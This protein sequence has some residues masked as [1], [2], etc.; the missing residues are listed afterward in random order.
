MCAVGAVPA[1]AQD[2]PEAKIRISVKG[3]RGAEAGDTVRYRFSVRNVGRLALD[4]V[5]ATTRLPRSLKFLRGGEFRSAKR[6]VLFPL[7][8]IAPGRV[9]SRI[10][11]VRVADDVEPDGRIELHAKVSA[12]PVSDDE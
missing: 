2:E 7:G 8:R 10:L 9:R 3:G 4:S 1:T 12:R 6:L 11:V 5:R